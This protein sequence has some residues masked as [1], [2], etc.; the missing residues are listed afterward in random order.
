MRVCGSMTSIGVGPLRV[1]DGKVDADENKKHPKA[2]PATTQKTR[3]H[4]CSSAQSEE[5]DR[6][7]T[8]TQSPGR[9]AQ[10][11]VFN[12]IGLS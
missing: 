8:A 7:E 11:P 6:V 9:P 10:S 2:L 5:S 1:F 4:G 12:P 3:T